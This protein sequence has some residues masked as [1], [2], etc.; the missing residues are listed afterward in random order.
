MQ[1]NSG[2][3]KGKRHKE[4]APLE[5]GDAAKSENNRKNHGR[6]TASKRRSRR[7]QKRSCR[8]ASVQANGTSENRKI[9]ERDTWK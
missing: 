3:N 2:K 4:F 9:K 5:S 7:W 6:A 1:G 8:D